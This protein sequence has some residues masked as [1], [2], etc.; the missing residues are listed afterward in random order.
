L[1]ERETDRRTETQTEREL[2]R[3]EKKK[4]CKIERLR[5][6]KGTIER[7]RVRVKEICMVRHYES[8]RGCERK[9]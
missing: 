1:S 6:R 8:E 4:R 2:K 7:E 9:I 5:A 3:R